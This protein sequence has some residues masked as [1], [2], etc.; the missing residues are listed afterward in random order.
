MRVVTLCL[1]TLAAQETEIPRQPMPRLLVGLPFREALHQPLSAAWDQVPLRVLLRR[2]ETERR[3]AILL[4]RRIDPTPPYT[5]RFTEESLLAALETIGQQAQA[6]VSHSDRVIYLGP[7][8][9]ADWL[10]TAIEQA[11]SRLSEKTL[12][13]SEQRRFDL[14]RGQT[15]AWPDLSTPRDILEQI[16]TAYDL[17]LE[18]LDA[19]PHDLWAS[20][21]LP[22]VTA[23]EALTLVLIQFPLSWD[24]Q[25]GGQG[26]RVKPWV[27][28]PLIERR[29]RLRGSPAEVL[30]KWQDHL[31][32]ATVRV[33]GQ[34]LVVQ[35][36]TEDHRQAQALRLGVSGS[37]GPVIREPQPL[38]RRLFTLQ[39]ERVPLRTILRELEQTGVRFEYD[40]AELAQAGISLDQ[41]I[42]LDVQKVRADEF[43]E[44]VLGKAGLQFEID[45]LTVTLRPR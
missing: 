36:R 23:A 24:W 30:S 42:T 40:P 12:A 1:L 25:P 21:T 43:F 44:A 6:A 33:E 45:H 35:G 18:G 32:R 7:P 2:I 27:N 41:P 22:A 20:A 5:V 39:V 14:Q 19:V 11:E 28:P 31:P 4:D 3:V 10:Q 16:A 17:T 37:R 9:A 13:I 26:V 8:Q 34:E 29:Y 38:R 15:F